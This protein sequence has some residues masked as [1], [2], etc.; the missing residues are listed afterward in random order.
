VGWK[1]VSDR[2][3]SISSFELAPFYLRRC[4]LDATL[5]MSVAVCTMDILIRLPLGRPFLAR[6]QPERDISSFV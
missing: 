1:M 5:A 4:R 3:E 2:D 6:H